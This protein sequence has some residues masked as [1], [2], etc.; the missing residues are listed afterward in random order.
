MLESLSGSKLYLNKNV[1]KR[2]IERVWQEYL[3]LTTLWYD[4][5]GGSE[6][7]RKPG[8]GPRTEEMAHQISETSQ[9]ESLRYFESLWSTLLAPDVDLPSKLEQLLAD[10]TEE[11]DLEYG[12]LSGIDL[13]EN[14]Q[15]YEVVHG[16]H[17]VLQSGRSVPLS[18]TYC[19]KTIA[20]PEGTIAVSDAVAE[21]WEDDPAYEKFGLGTYVGTTVAIEDRLYGTLCFASQ[22][23]RDE[24]LTDEE[25][26]LVEMYSWWVSYELERWGG[27]QT[28]GPPTPFEVPETPSVA[29]LDLMVEA[30]SKQARRFVLLTLLEAEPED[31]IDIL[32]RTILNEEQRIALRHSHLPKLDQDEFI[33]WDRDSNTIRRG[34]NFSEIKPLL[35]L[36]RTYTE[37]FSE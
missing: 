10:E 19:R 34:E 22:E 3:S 23:P 28:Y 14:T 18:V 20:D 9:D 36:L 25:L 17:D 12:F 30:L 16:T 35:R 5:R 33:E 15:R 8:S 26:T 1:K 7:V 4:N 21:G 6:V 31:S 29:E 11:F 32:E 24:P 27:P 13:K 37:G 2:N